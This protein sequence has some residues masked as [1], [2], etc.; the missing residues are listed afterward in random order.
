MYGAGTHYQQF[1]GKKLKI[2]AH[3]C[4]VVSRAHNTLLLHRPYSMFHSLAWRDFLPTPH[5]SSH[6]HVLQTAPSSLAHLSHTWPH[7]NDF[8]TSITTISC[9]T[10]I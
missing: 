10:Y 7:L 9:Q 6:G 1:T 2:Q 4:I 8:D 5:W 3:A